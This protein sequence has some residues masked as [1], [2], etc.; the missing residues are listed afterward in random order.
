MN[1]ESSCPRKGIA[2]TAT[3][4]VSTRVHHNTLADVEFDALTLPVA[5]QRMLQ[6]RSAEMQEG[7]IRLFKLYASDRSQLGCCSHFASFRDMPASKADSLA[8]ELVVFLSG[9]LEPQAATA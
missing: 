1:F 3:P 7:F 6:Q 9:I 2:Q 8:K 4:F 5:L